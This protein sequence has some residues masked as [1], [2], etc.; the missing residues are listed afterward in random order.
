MGSIDT[1]RLTE[2]DREVDALYGSERWTRAEFERLWAR[3][4]EASG[5]DASALD[6]LRIFAEPTWLTAAELGPFRALGHRRIPRVVAELID[7]VDRGWVPHLALGPSEAVHWN[8]AL[9]PSGTVQVDF[10]N[11]GGLRVTIRCDASDFSGFEGGLHGYAIGA[12]ADDTVRTSHQGAWVLTGAGAS[13]G[14]VRSQYDAGGG[15]NCHATLRVPQW[16]AHLDL[17]VPRLW[18]APLQDPIELHFGNLNIDH[19]YALDGRLVAGGGRWGNWCLRGNYSY[20]LITVKLAESEQQYLIVDP[21]PDAAALDDDALY[22]DRLAIQFAFGAAIKV[23]RMFGVRDGRVVACRGS[24]PYAYKTPSPEPAITEDSVQSSPWVEVFVKRLSAALAPATDPKL[25]VA[26]HAYLG[27]LDGMVDRQFR[28]LYNALVAMAYWTRP[29]SDV[30]A[31]RLVNDEDG[32]RRWVSERANEIAALSSMPEQLARN[33]A[34]AAQP[35][36]R[37][38]IEAALARL[39]LQVPVDVLGP[40]FSYAAQMRA[41]GYMTAGVDRTALEIIREAQ[42]IRALRT[43]LVAVVAGAIGYRGP[44]RNELPGRGPPPAWWKVDPGEAVRARPYSCVT[45]PID[46]AVP[47]V[48][49]GDILLIVENS[50]AVVIVR[51]LLRAARLL[52]SRFHVVS[53]VGRA[54][55]LQLVGAIRSARPTARFGVVASTRSRN[56]AM[57]EQELRSEDALRNV[58]V[59]LPAVSSVHCWALA[60]DRLVRRCVGGDA[61]LLEELDSAPL[62]EELSD[63]RDVAFRFL[64]PP[65]KWDV[66]RESDIYRACARSPS[67]RAF[68]AWAAQ[69]VGM[70]LDLPIESVGRSIGRD[71]IAGLIREMVPGHVVIW[72][73]LDGETYTADDLS[74]QVEQGTSIGQQ[75]ARDV[76]RV[77]IDFL[78]R[79]AARKGG[80]K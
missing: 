28:E 75:Y 40:V 34:H 52:E 56:L 11:D 38:E 19:S 14:S 24:S 17:G 73:T 67:L 4:L 37:Q 10:E 43:L 1:G 49:E 31:G 71:A 27:S 44:I 5:G 80:Q 69:A 41:T 7:S 78:R 13:I 29:E 26:T 45:S 57:G 8:G 33:L 58:E 6:F 64:G 79:S 51:E 23:P 18:I 22:R 3:G 76:V 60:D 36:P 55:M 15:R 9:V 47:A 61:D 62:P 66:L 59:L 21:G 77:A 72:R 46:L 39:G 63:P 42:T 70:D 20:F 74:R 48:G 16:Q 25:F 12:I 50:D 32:W 54:G 68:L 53:G 2:I 30:G 65:E 35:T